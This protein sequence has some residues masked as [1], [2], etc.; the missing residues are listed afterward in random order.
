MTDYYRDDSIDLETLPDKSQEFEVERN[1]RDQLVLDAIETLDKRSR[2][3]IE[4]RYG[5]TGEPPK[6]INDIAM[7]FG[8]SNARVGQLRKKALEKICVY[9]A[10]KYKF[11][12]QEITVSP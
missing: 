7:M 11:P 5:L 10:K 9:I 3:I 1:E 2:E 12:L 4:L 6:K 8:V